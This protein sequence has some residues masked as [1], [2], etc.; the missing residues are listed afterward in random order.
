LAIKFLKVD[1]GAEPVFFGFADNFV[2][3]ILRPRST[4]PGERSGWNDDNA[5]LSRRLTRRF[6]PAGA[7][8]GQQAVSGSRSRRDNSLLPATTR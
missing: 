6:D 1:Q 5:K 7:L 8:D 2:V 4:A 3:V